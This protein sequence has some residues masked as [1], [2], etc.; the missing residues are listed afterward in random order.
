MD[1]MIATSSTRIS[2]SRRITLR[3]ELSP[4][5][6]DAHLRCHANPAKCGGIQARSTVSAFE[7][8]RAS[9]P[10]TRIAFAPIQAVA[11][12]MATP[13]VV[14]TK[15]KIGCR[16]ALCGLSSATTI[17]TAMVI[18]VVMISSDRCPSSLR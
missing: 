2:A 11:T 16:Q 17:M 12:P 4:R 5:L 13:T 6:T 9:G 3:G 8:S 10:V 14:S 1:M 7:V 15:C 18:P